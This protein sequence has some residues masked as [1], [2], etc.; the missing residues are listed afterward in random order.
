MK[1]KEIEALESYIKTENEHWNEFTFEMLCEILQQGQF[2]NPEI[3]L[4]LFSN[5]IDTFTEHHEHPIKAVQLFAGELDKNKLTASQKIFIYEWVCKYLKQSEFDFDSKP[6]K[7]LLNSKKEKLK[8][9][10]QPIKPLTRNIRDTLK[11]MMQKELEALPETLKELDTVQR[12]NILCK[13]IPFILPKVDSVHHEQGEPDEF[14]I[15]T[16][17]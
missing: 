4:Q 6:I 13:L 17:Q 14:T 15:K 8:S 12:L 11:A 10:N 16:Y 1:A 2:E 5:S 7:D 3:P 9:E